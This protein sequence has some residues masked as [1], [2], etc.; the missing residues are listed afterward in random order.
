MVILSCI[1]DAKGDHDLV[2][3]RRLG[4][5]HAERAEIGGHL[6][7]QRIAP[8]RECRALEE[9]RMPTAGIPAATFK[10]CV[11]SLPI[12]VLPRITARSP[13]ELYR[14]TARMVC[15]PC[16]FAPQ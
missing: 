2:E 13:E 16:A 1:R 15:T 3:K 10:T 4:K 5:H 7:R 12:E 11:V 8:R 14:A 9:T 6:K